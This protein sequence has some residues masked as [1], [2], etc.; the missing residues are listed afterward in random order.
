MK[1]KTIIIIII[2][3]GILSIVY[4]VQDGQFWMLKT[5]DLGLSIYRVGGCCV[6]G[7]FSVTWILDCFVSGSIRTGLGTMA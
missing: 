7:F 4:S 6:V 2:R 3:A 1:I 5:W